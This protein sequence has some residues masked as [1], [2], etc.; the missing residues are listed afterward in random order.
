MTKRLERIATVSMTRFMNG[1]S[2]EFFFN[3][4]SSYLH[5]PV[6][7]KRFKKQL[8]VLENLYSGTFKRF[9]T[10]LPSK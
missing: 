2:K 10:P 8:G 1:L 7:K 5:L 6:H 9:I 3:S 4:R